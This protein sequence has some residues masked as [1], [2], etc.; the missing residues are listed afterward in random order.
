MNIPPVLNAEAILKA[1]PGGLS[2]LDASVEVTTENRR[3]FCA[4]QASIKKAV[5]TFKKAGFSVSSVGKMSIA[6]TGSAVMFQ[7]TFNVT[8]V[9]N[10][11][12]NVTTENAVRPG[13]IDPKGFLE[14]ELEAIVLDQAKEQYQVYHGSDPPIMD[15]SNI[16]RY[17]PADVPVLLGFLSPEQFVSVKQK[18]NRL[19]LKSKYKVIVHVLDAGFYNHSYFK[20]Y[21]GR[22]VSVSYNAI[23]FKQYAKYIND[24]ESFL[25]DLED[26]KNT[27]QTEDITGNRLYKEVLATDPAKYTSEL[28]EL[29]RPLR[30]KTALKK[31]IAEYPLFQGIDEAA[32][33]IAVFRNQDDEKYGHGTR[34]VASLF[35]ILDLLDPSYVEVRMYR[36]TPGSRLNDFFSRFDNVSELKVRR[37][38]IHIINCSYG[39]PETL[40]NDD[41]RKITV[42]KA[43]ALAAKKA[44][45]LFSS[46]N[47]ERD[48]IKFKNFEPQQPDLFS[49]GG[50]YK[51][52][53]EIVASDFAHGYQLVPDE[54]K[55]IPDICGLCG[56]YTDDDFD[57]GVVWLPF[58]DY[59]A[60][61]EA[62]LSLGGTSFA[63]P[64]V[65]ATCAVL[66]MLKPGL[67][68]ID[69]KSILANE[70]DRIT[71]G[72][73][74]APTGAQPVDAKSRGLVNVRKSMIAVCELLKQTK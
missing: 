53:N 57:G 48:G 10:D 61:E 29:L 35:P 21:M 45:I 49:V 68:L 31:L 59:D 37:N 65:A 70:C 54:K 2:L 20:K 30:T 62:W 14:D 42:Q 8:I 52:G 5:D 51:N 11:F 63:A 4:D 22:K 55:L 69:L 39:T 9:T 46:G 7:H 27:S 50:A 71:S 26:I 17:E 28:R 18:L 73:F 60:G 1:R 36:D 41:A 43:I 25:I 44:V 40:Q 24:L 64:Q 6:I 23:A 12:G 13:V 72:D 66:K 74:Y 67:D 56:K 16:C 58:Y 33:A 3:K 47:R 34:V 19:L 15:P 32:N 38:E